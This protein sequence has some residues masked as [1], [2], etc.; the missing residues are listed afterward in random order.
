MIAGKAMEVAQAQKF[1]MP[2]KELRMLW[3]AF[4]IRGG[5]AVLF[6]GI[7]FYSGSLL[8]TIF[9]DPVMLVFL[10]DPRFLHPEQWHSPWRGLRLCG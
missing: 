7:L 6:S 9:F 5:G 4:A 1:E 2:M 10:A 8:G 3:W